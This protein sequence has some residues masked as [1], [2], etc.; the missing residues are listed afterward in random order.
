M[1]ILEGAWPRSGGIPPR[2]GS[3]ALFYATSSNFASSVAVAVAEA[4]QYVRA[5]A[6]LHADEQ[7]QAIIA[8]IMAWRRGGISYGKIAERLN[9]EGIKGKHGGAFHA[10]TIHKIVG[11][12]LHQ[13]DLA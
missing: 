2:L 7:E 8:K 1:H 4:T 11:N 9:A 3:G 10:S 13:V 5:G 6:A 12:D